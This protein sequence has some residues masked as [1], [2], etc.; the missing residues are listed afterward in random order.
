MGEG[1]SEWERQTSTSTSSANEQC[2][3]VEP[4][5]LLDT[6]RFTDVYAPDAGRVGERVG[7]RAGERVILCRQLV[8]R[9]RRVRDLRPLLIRAS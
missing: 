6:H 7:D 8:L 4:S 2:Q 5:W 3:I 9:R 1:V